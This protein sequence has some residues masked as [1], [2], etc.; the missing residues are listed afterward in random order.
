MGFPFPLV[1]FPFP[2]VVAPLSLPIACCG[3]SCPFG[4][5]S[6]PFAG[7][8]FPLVVFPFPCLLLVVVA[9]VPFVC[10]FL[11]L[12]LLLLSVLFRCVFH[13]CVSIA[14]PAASIA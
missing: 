1:V 12:L 5:G 14:G 11:S 7:V 10:G 2:L 13:G 3:V 6:R 9:H 4:G 8:P